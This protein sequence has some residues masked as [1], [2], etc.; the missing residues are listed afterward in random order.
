VLDI[1]VQNMAKMVNKGLLDNDIYT[2]S[3]IRNVIV[4]ALQVTKI[5]S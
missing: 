4:L 3:K 2:V 1:A 5:N